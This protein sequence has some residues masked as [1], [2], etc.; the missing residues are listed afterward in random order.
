MIE[1]IRRFVESEVTEIKSSFERLFGSDEFR[2]RIAGLPA[3]ERDDAIAATY[4]DLLKDT[5]RY[6]Y[7]SMAVVLHP[8]LKSLQILLP[9]IRHSEYQGN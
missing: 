7:G 8:D 9:V 6:D 5:G 2:T 3:V 1:H 4:L